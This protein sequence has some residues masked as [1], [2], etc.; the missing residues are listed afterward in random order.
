MSITQRQPTPEQLIAMREFADLC[1][2]ALEFIGKY[3]MNLASQSASIKINEAMMW[4]HSFLLN[5]GS[6]LK[7]DP[8]NGNA[9]VELKAEKEQVVSLN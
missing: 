2:N 4:M 8:M 7:E 3:E 1:A 9:P 5:G 6:L